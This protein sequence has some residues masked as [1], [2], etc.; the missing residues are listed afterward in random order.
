MMGGVEEGRG[1]FKKQLH[2][3]GRMSLRFKR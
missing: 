3:C 2:G 1:G